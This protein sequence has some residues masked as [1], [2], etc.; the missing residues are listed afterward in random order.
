LHRHSPRHRHP[1]P[2]GPP[3]PPPRPSPPPPPRNRPPRRRPSLL[4]RLPGRA[5]RTARSRPTGR[6]RP[7]PSHRRSPRRRRPPV[8]PPRGRPT[9]LHPG[10]TR[11]RGGRVLR[12]RSHIAVKHGMCWPTGG[13]PPPAAEGR[14]RRRVFCIMSFTRLFGRGAGGWNCA[15]PACQR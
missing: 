4:P 5:R 6:R 15:T 14:S 10:C 8:P 7:S 9:S 3:G 12:A 13:C 11:W 2:P 1:P